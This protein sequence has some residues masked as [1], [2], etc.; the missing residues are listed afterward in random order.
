MMGWG[1]QGYGMWGMGGFGWIIMI[2]FWVVVIAG[3]VMLFRHFLSGT[4]TGHPAGQDRD[5]IRILEQRFANGEIDIQEF[6]ERKKILLDGKKGV[7]GM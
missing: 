5:P 7:T 4:G 1:N 3:L 6:E 2:L